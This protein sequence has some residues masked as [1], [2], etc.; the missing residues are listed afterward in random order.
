[1]DERAWMVEVSMAK[2]GVGAELRGSEG[3]DQRSYK[4]IGDR[5]LPTV[6]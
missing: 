4:D 3:S 1:M 5:K 6:P 2:G